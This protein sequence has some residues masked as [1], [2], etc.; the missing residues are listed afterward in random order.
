MQTCGNAEKLPATEVTEHPKKKKATTKK[1]RICK[2]ASTCLTLSFL[3]VEQG[4]ADSWLHSWLRSWLRSRMHSWLQGHAKLYADR[5]KT[6]NPDPA[7]V[8]G[9]NKAKSYKEKRF[10]QP[11]NVF[12]E[13]A[14]DVTSETMSLHMRK[15]KVYWRTSG[16]TA[17]Y[18]ILLASAAMH[19]RTS[20][21][22]SMHAEE[23]CRSRHCRTCCLLAYFIGSEKMIWHIPR[24]EKECSCTAR[25]GFVLSQVR[26][27]VAIS[28]I[29]SP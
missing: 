14:R 5:K 3:C 21:A 16:K 2:N 8:S 15:S 29:F 11:A 22:C 27:A 17:R 23:L 10:F 18:K 20:T 13:S 9:A 26:E 24:P 6:A 19:Q 4:T 25:V 28:G 12:M 7:W 1:R